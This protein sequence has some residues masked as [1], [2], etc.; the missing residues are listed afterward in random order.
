MIVVGGKNENRDLLATTEA[1]DSTSETWQ[2]LG[3]ITHGQGKTMHCQVDLPSD[4]SC[5]STIANVH[6]SVHYQQAERLKS[7]ER[8]PEV[9]RLNG[10]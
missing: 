8:R 4:F 5:F 7:R 3:N 1:Y 10:R 9:D 6:L 2:S